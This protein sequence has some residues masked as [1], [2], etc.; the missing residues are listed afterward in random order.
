VNKKGISTLVIVAIIVIAV[1]IGGIA[2]YVWYSGGG[3]EEPTPTPTPT[4]DIEGATSMRFDVNAT[5]E[6]ALEVDRF[7]VKNLGT[8]D[9]LLRVDQTDAQGNEFTY[10]MNQTAQTVWADF[11]TG[12]MEYSENFEDQ[13]WNNELIGYVAV[14]SYMDALADWS[15]TGDYEGDSFIIY[16]IVVDPTIEDSVFQPT[17]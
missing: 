15:G 10:L 12:F 8:S 6:G 14:E 11:G 16:N 17:S 13:Y 3:E 2:V 5:V 7:T 1:V 4:P 9:V